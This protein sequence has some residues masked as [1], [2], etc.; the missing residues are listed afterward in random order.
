MGISQEALADRPVDVLVYGYND[1]V[2]PIT[3]GHI[4]LLESRGYVVEVTDGPVT[5]EQM[6]KASVVVGWGLNVKDAEAREGACRVR[7]WGRPPVVACWTHSTATCGTEEKP[8]WYDFTK[9]A[10]GFKFDGDVQHGV[11]LPAEGSEL[12]PVWN[13]PNTCCRSSPT[14]A[15]THM[16]R[17]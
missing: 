10:F 6:A 7:V 3:T 8:C 16:W 2:R 5:A 4:T 1:G 13:S 12:H 17:R 11:V 9:E 14:G 15:V